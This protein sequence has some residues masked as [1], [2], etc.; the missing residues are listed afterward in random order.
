MEEH[1]GYY[2]YILQPRGAG[3]AKGTRSSE[4]ALGGLSLASTHWG[5]LR[6]LQ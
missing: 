1:P 3:A 5:A 6:I 4:V 2:L